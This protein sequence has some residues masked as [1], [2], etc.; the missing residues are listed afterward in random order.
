MIV[1]HAIIHLLTFQYKLTKRWSWEEADDQWN[2]NVYIDPSYT[3]INKWKKCQ[4]SKGC[5][6]TLAININVEL[7]LISLLMR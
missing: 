5:E 7:L 3:S 4:N 2:V 1:E 6:R